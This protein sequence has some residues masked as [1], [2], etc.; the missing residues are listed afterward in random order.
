MRLTRKNECKY[1]VGNKCNMGLLYLCIKIF[2]GRLIDVTL[3]TL[4]TMLLVKGKRN[5]ATIIG[6]IDVFIWF[7]VVDFCFNWKLKWKFN[8][9]LSTSC[10]TYLLSIGILLLTPMS[11]AN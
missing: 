1:P 7:I 10:R 5:L 11:E 3:S 9:K 2:C 6:F 4:Q 8:W